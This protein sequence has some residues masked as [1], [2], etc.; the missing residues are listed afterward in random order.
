MDVAL[1]D[2]LLVVRQVPNVIDEE[3][4]AT[5]RQVRRLADPRLLLVAAREL[6][7]ELL[8]FVRQDE[9]LWGEVVDAAE[10]GLSCEKLLEG[11]A[12]PHLFDQAT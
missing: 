8:V 12:Y 10:D 7:H 2:A 4:L 11:G 9:G 1:D 6:L 5:A 3:N